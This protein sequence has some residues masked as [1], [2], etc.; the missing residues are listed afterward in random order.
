MSKN[1]LA[2]SIVHISIYSKLFGISKLNNLAEE[3][4]VGI[5][6]FIYIYIYAY[7][8]IEY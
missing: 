2:H 8:H 1:S 3:I 7:S 6:I 4:S 5:H